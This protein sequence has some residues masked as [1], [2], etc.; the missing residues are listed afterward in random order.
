MMSFAVE[1]E[2]RVPLDEFQEFI[3][4]YLPNEFDCV[5][6]G[7]PVAISRDQDIVVNFAAANDGNEP[8][9]WSETPKA[10]NEWLEL[11]K[12]ND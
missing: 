12:K 3:R 7:P 6:L 1:G 5:L 8:S 11:E 2:V 4:G 9:D 10:L